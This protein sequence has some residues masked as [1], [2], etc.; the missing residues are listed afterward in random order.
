MTLQP[1]AAIRAATRRL[2]N[3]GLVLLV[4]AFVLAA[5]AVFTGAYQVRPVLSG[6]MEPTLHIGGVVVTQ[7]IPLGA[8][9]P[10]DILVVTD[11]YDHTRLVVHR[12][13]AITRT[14]AATMVNTKGDHNAVPDPWTLRMHGDSAYRVIATVPYIGYAAIWLHQ[15]AI[16]GHLVPIGIGLLTVALV[17]LLWPSKTET[18]TKTEHSSADPGPDAVTHP[19]GDPEMPTKSSRPGPAADRSAAPARDPLVGAG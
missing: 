18:P 19:A 12:V 15:P 11:P 6:S 10:R 13:T 8:V 14:P 5:V 1:S 9:Q 7:R 16:G 2:V 4:L 3:T 17:V